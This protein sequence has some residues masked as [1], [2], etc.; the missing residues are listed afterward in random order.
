[1]LAQGVDRVVVEG[2]RRR[3]HRTP[4]D[5]SPAGSSAPFTCDSGPN[6]PVE[7]RYEQAL[8]ENANRATPNAGTKGLRTDSS[9]V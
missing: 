8:C 1:V 2:V 9:G 4:P 5:G 3:P 7:M 6:V